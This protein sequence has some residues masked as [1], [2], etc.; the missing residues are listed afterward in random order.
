MLSLVNMPFTFNGSGYTVAG[1]TGVSGGG[2]K[3]VSAS[4]FA[5]AVFLD[6]MVS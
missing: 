3:K 6:A 4:A 1:M 5:L 2:G